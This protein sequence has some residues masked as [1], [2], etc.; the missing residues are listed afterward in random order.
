L[1]Y[2]VTK[3]LEAAF[4]Q[5]SPKVQQEALLWVNNAI[6]EFGFQVSVIFINI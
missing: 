4:E 2:V 6:K 5:K 1:E 3:V